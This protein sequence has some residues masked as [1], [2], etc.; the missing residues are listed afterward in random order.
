MSFKIT[1]PNAPG[2]N[3]FKVPHQPARQSALASAHVRGRGFIANDDSDSDDNAADHTKG[4]EEEEE[5]GWDLDTKGNAYVSFSLFSHAGQCVR[6]GLHLTRLVSTATSRRHHHRK[7]RETKPKAAPLTIA[8]LANKDW[9]NSS[10][11]TKTQVATVPSRAASSSR[12]LPPGAEQ[13]LSTEPIVTREVNDGDDLNSGGLILSG[14]KKDQASAAVS[15]EPMEET[16]EDATAGKAAAAERT[17]LTLE[18]RAMKALLAGDADE[19]E[20][21]IE[22]IQSMENKRQVPISEE[23]AFRRDVETRPEGVR[24]GP[25][26]MRLHIW[27]TTSPSADNLLPPS[28]PSMEDYQRIPVAS[29]GL[30][31]LKGMGWKEGTAASRTR[32][33]LEQPYVPTA[34]P[35]LLGIGAKERAPVELGKGEKK[36][37]EWKIREEARKYVPVLK[38]QREVSKAVHS[39]DLAAGQRML[40]SCCLYH[41]S[42]SSASSAVATPPGTSFRR[43]RSSSSSPPPRRRDDDRSSSSRRDRSRSRDRD[44]DYD[45]DRDRDHRRDDRDWDNRDREN[46]AGRESGR[47]SRPRDDRDRDDRRSRDDRGRDGRNSSRG[48]GYDDDVRRDRRRYGDDGD[49]DRDRDRVRRNER[50]SDRRR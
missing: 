44:R 19:P 50:E 47:S 11:A 7:Y 13:A 33:G 34:R 4:V 43:P 35:S 10:R 22:A 23:E 5:I 27:V 8:P 3:G 42:S 17:S 48:E 6:V 2:G 25:E 31:L 21:E 49:R 18:Q 15:A 45:R 20:E 38:V 32:K 36:K 40:M 41:Q 46:R 1:N 37:K 26:P 39:V 16:G 9:K 14:R 28:Q 30:A 29:F 12:Y 24:Q